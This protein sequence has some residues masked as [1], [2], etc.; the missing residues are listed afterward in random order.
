MS[1][2]L[3]DP[4]R[5][6]EKHDQS[7]LAERI[8]GQAFRDMTPAAPL[9]STALARIA[10]RV[11]ESASVPRPRR[12]LRWAL[13][14]CALLLGGATAASAQH[15][16]ILPRWL[17][18]TF[19]SQSKLVS[20]QQY[21]PATSRQGHAKPR[22]VELPA[23]PVQ[24]KGDTN[25][26]ESSVPS[27]SRAPATTSLDLNRPVGPMASG[28]REARRSVPREDRSSRTA[29]TPLGMGT[30]T[31]TAPAES[32]SAPSIELRPA[33]A[34]APAPPLPA[35]A[36]APAPVERG[37]HLALVERNG[38]TP[39]LVKTV[40]A[41]KPTVDPPAVAGGAQHAA[42]YL[43][44]AIRALRVEHSPKNALALLDHHSAELHH[45]FA[46]ESLLLRVEA[47]LALGQKSQVLWLLDET[48]LS[49]LK[50]SRSLLVTRGQLRAAANR[51][52][53]AIGDFDRVL[54]AE[55]SKQALLER[56]LCK[57]RLGDPVGAQLDRHR[58]RREF[59]VEAAP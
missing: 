1:G 48:S 59:A 40:P 35:P 21:A 15:L 23:A 43:S 33:L 17:V 10:A 20:H 18:R 27:D 56:A 3:K 30:P 4:P 49:D 51:C 29:T 44:Q 8:A 24:A 54:A 53:E 7:N 32:A 31:A 19:A 5:L 57:E 37:L 46:N 14:C 45:A 28:S 41:A 42:K 58:V 38:E 25:K 13:V 26:A 9:S 11:E 34:P 47:M 6:K 36:P 2:F 50:H 12:R 22:A 16:D 55:P 52:S 39:A